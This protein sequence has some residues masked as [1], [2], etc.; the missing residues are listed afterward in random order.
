MCKQLI[1]LPN[2]VHSTV[3]YRT[4]HEYRSTVPVQYSTEYRYRYLSITRCPVSAVSV[5][6]PPVGNQITNV[7][8][9]GTRSACV[10]THCTSESCCW[11]VPECRCCSQ[12]HCAHIQL[13]GVCPKP[14]LRQRECRRNCIAFGECG[15]VRQAR[16]QAGSQ[17][18]RTALRPYPQLCQRA[19]GSSDRPIGQRALQRRKT[20]GWRR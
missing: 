12:R 4:V 19:A 16:Q 5:S 11:S 1:V 14:R 15:M 20:N 17:C 8:E 10:Y 7:T 18:C 13:E 2:S 3:Q 6:R 9:D